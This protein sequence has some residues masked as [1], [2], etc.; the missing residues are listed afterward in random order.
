LIVSVV[1]VAGKMF[2]TFLGVR[3]SGQP[4]P[5]ATRAG[6]ALAQIGE[7]SFIIASLGIALGKMDSFLYSVAVSVAVITTFTTPYLIRLANR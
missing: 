7:F 2:S 1:T 6:F 4:M 5:V 3:L